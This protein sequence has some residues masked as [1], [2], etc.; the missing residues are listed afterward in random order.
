MSASSAPAWSPAA[1]PDR[2][3]AGRVIALVLGIL[4][5]LPALALIAGGGVLLWADQSERDDGFLMSP[6]GSVSTD[7]YALVSD[8]IE[9]ST[10][11]D[12]VPVSG[13]LGT[14]LVQATATGPDLFVGIGPSDEVAA[15]LGTVQR[16]VIDDLGNDGAV[17][18]REVSGDAPAGPPA[19]QQ[20]WTEQASGGG[21]Q[22]LEWDPD[23]GDWTV[24]VMNADGS[25]GVD[26]DLRVGAELP[27]LTGIA[28]GL[29][30]GGVVLTAIAVL[31]I[32]LAA[33]RRRPRAQFPPS[34]PPVAAGPP[35]A[36]QPPAPRA[37]TSGDPVRGSSRDQVT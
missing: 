35:P 22:Q 31:I 14:T 27:A 20:F 7:G 26:A 15:Y 32:V 17:I 34:G 36:W 10:S 9:L 19:A 16:A 29:L 8:R 5:L 3:G 1:P 2:W 4:L 6:T 13:A 37:D 11:G 23:G 24:V 33:R 21:R 18:G 28:W 25:A 30:I 12:W